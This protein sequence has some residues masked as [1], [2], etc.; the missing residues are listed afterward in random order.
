MKE[1][2]DKSLY[3]DFEDER[4][5]GFSVEDFEILREA[6][7]E[8][9]PG[10]ISEKVYFLLD[11]VQV[12]DGWEKFCRRLVEKS[13]AE[14]VVAGSSS[15]IYLDNISTQLRGRAWSIEVFPFSFK[16]FVIFKGIK[17]GAIH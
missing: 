17:P 3:I 12:V 15:K 1:N 13:P 11:E 8:L 6:F 2:P 7:Y 10:L 9:F 5:D 14:V 4:L 16:E